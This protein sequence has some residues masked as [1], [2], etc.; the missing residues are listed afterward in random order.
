MK[1]LSII[2]PVYN[3]EHTIA[4]VLSALNSIHLPAWKHEIIIIDDGSTDSTRKRIQ[5]KL[6]LLPHASLIIHSKNSGKG[7]AVQSGMKK[8]KGEY[9][10]IQDADME[11]SPGDISRLLKPIAEGRAEVVYGTR[12]NRL[13]NLKRDERTFRFLAHYFGNRILSL[14]VSILYAHPLTDIETGYKIFPRAIF[15]K[16]NFTSRGF[17]FE[18]EITA[19][20][21]KSGYKITEIPITTNPRGYKEGKKLR[22]V[23]DGLHAVWTI[24]KCRFID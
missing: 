22:T 14:L 1:S 3:E 5:N 15:K 21:L 17:E 4:R 10:L 8:A 2:I 7:T 9:I 18:P 20:L 6:S 19:K 13:P 12:L 11:Y 23:P 16:A 24:V